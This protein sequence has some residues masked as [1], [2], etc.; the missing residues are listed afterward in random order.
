MRHL[1]R[2][3]TFGKCDGYVSV[4]I[5]ANGQP[6]QSPVGPIQKSL[7]IP[8]T[9]DPDYQDKNFGGQIK[10]LFFMYPPNTGAMSELQFEVKAMD[11]ER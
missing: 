9:Y 5:R 6:L 4:A 7:M 3:D 10:G 11:W 8:K 2:M 1:P